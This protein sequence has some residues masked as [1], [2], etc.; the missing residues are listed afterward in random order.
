[1]QFDDIRGH[2][3]DGSIPF[4]TLLGLAYLNGMDVN[5]DYSEALRW[6]S[7]AAAIGTPRAMANLGYMYAEGL[8][9]RRS[10]SH[11]YW[12]FKRSTSEFASQLGLARLYASGDGVKR[13]RKLAVKWY[14]IAVS[15]YPESE[16][17]PELDEARD[18]ILANS[19]ICRRQM[20]GCSLQVE[21]KQLAMYRDMV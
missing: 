14:S 18:Y 6:L 9:V 10:S 12:L 11:A 20:N 4:T 3:V 5:I 13:N 21:L 1:M 17:D 16:S 2:A 19:V 7:I 8:G 15:Q